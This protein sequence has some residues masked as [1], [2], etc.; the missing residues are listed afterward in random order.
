VKEK[1]KEQRDRC[2]KVNKR[3][4]RGEKEKRKTTRLFERGKKMSETARKSFSFSRSG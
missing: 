3:R 2:L 4:N 1:K